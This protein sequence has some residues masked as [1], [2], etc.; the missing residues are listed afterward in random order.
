MAAS[1]YNIL[2]EQ[3]ADFKM[4]L[5]PTSLTLDFTGST[6]RGQIRRRYS[7]A[8]PIA[9]FTV[10]TGTDGTGFY[11]DFALTAVETAAIPVESGTT[12]NKRNSKYCYDVEIVMAADGKVIRL[13][14]GIVEVSPEVTR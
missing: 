8:D 13:I 2:I 4:R 12:Y 10:T 6:G 1:E 3:G 5:R 9:A 14:E 7:D 11:L